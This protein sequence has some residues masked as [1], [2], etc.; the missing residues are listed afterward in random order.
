[1]KYIK[2][3]NDPTYWL[4]QDNGKRIPMKDI[5]DVYAHGLH[6]VET[7]E[8]SEMESYPIEKPKKEAELSTNATT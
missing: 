5:Q 6:E 3:D 7:V 2:L 4:L 8:L 1:M